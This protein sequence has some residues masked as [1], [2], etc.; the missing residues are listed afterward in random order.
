MLKTQYGWRLSIVGAI[1]TA[2]TTGMAIAIGFGAPF[3]FNGYLFRWAGL[4]TIFCGLVAFA[5]LMRVKSTDHAALAYVSLAGCCGAISEGILSAIEGSAIRVRFLLVLFNLV[6]IAALSSAGAAISLPAFLRAHRY[7]QVGQAAPTGEAVVVG[8]RWIVVVSLVAAVV[9]YA[10]SWFRERWEPWRGYSFL[11][12]GVV[13]AVG[14]VVMLGGIW[15]RRRCAPNPPQ[16]YRPN[17][18]PK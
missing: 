16:V 2:L 18:P 6:C 10:L 15:Q 4:T 1:A 13:G 11:I 3:S 12:I 8:G 14:L 9:N 5:A 17:P 7:L